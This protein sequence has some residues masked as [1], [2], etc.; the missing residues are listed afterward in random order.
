MSRTFIFAYGCFCYAIFLGVFAYSVSFLGNFYVPNSID[1]APTMSFWP[2]LAINLGL[3]GVFAIQHSVM[4][5][6]AFKR[7]WTNVI[8]E[9]AERSTYV[10]FS[11]LAMIAVFLFWQPMG[12]SLWT[13]HTEPFRTIVVGLYFVGWG[14][15]F[16]ATWLINHFDLFGLRQVWYH[17]RG[18]KPPEMMFRV[19]GMYKYVRHPIYVGWLTIFWATPTMTAAHFVFAVMTT[20]YILIAIQFEEKDLVDEFGDDY[21]DYRENVGMLVPKPGASNTLLQD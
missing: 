12:G 20:A 17:L 2:A 9:A 8:P 3:L 19:P 16:Y 7:V 21:R 13:I 11:N 15:L 10:L 18:Q 14:V 6:P 5:R 4:A 1:A